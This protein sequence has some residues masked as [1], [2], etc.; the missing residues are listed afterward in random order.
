MSAPVAISEPR[1]GIRLVEL[2][3]P[4]RLNALNSEAVEALHATL[5]SIALDRSC[6][7]IVLSGRGRAFCAGLDLGGFGSSPGADESDPLQ[8]MFTGQKRLAG[9]VTHLRATPQ[10]VVAAVNG[11][12]MGAGM[13]LVLGSDI[14]LAGAS[15]RFGV[16]FIKLGVSGCDIGVS[17][18]L[19]RLVGVARAQELLL[20]GREVEAEEARAIGLVAD[21]FPDDGL[22]DGAL[23]VAERIAAYPPF[24]VAQTKE[25]MWAALEAPTLQLGMDIENRQQM[26][27]ASSGGLASASRAFSEKSSRRDDPDPPA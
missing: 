19:P 11:P 21:L 15:A 12:A 20:T 27:L 5:D 23:E 10:P 4:E 25:G 2:D 3:R 14:R 18:L 22:L 6:R 17:W 8:W 7:V 24:A 9:L 1:E 13:G 16:A 26:M